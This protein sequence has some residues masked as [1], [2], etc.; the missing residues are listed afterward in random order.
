MLI[1]GEYMMEGN[2]GNDKIN[3]SHVR[4]L[5]EELGNEFL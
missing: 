1:Q 4:E 2:G 5:S 3:L